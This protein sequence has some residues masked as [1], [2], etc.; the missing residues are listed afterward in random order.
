[1]NLDNPVQPKKQ[2]EEKIGTSF[3]VVG[4]NIIG[5]NIDADYESHWRDRDQRNDIIDRMKKGDASIAAVLNAIT[6]SLMS[7]KW[8]IEPAGESP[9]QI[10]HADFLKRA[11]FSELADGYKF[12]SFL[13]AALTCLP[14]GYSLFE[15][16]YKSKDGLVFWDRFAPRLQSSISRWGIEGEPWVDGHPTGIT[17][18]SYGSDETS[19]DEKKFTRTI[20]W[21]KLLRFTFNGA[22]NN[23]EG[24]S[25]L[26]PAYKHWYYK[27][28]YYKLQG[29]ANERWAAG[30]PV[31]FFNKDPSASEKTNIEGLLKSIRSNSQAFATFGPNIKEFKI[32][33]SDN[34]AASAQLENAIDGHDQKIYDSL[35]LGFLRLS[36]GKS[37][38]SYALSSDQSSFFMRS[39]QWV[40]DFIAGVMSS[41]GQKLIDINYGTQVDYPR[42]RTSDLT[43]TNV[44]E[45][46]KALVAGRTG[47]ILGWGDADEARARE[48]LGLPKLEQLGVGASARIIPQSAN[49]ATPAD[50]IN[51]LS[52]QKRVFTL[53]DANQPSDREKKFM[54]NIGEYENFLMSTYGRVE[55][56]VKAIESDL[57]DG[58]KA[59]YEKADTKR[60]DGHIVIIKSPKNSGLKKEALDL[61]KAQAKKMTRLLVKSANNNDARVMRILFDTTKSMAVSAIVDDEKYFAELSIDEKKFE[62]FQSGYRSNVNALIMNDPR[63]VSEQVIQNFNANTN[64]ELALSQLDGQIFNRNTLQLSIIS[65][66]RGAYNAAQY[67]INQTRGFTLY[68]VLAPKVV[69]NKLDLYGLTAKLLFSIYTVAQLDKAV[70]ELTDSRTANVVNGLGLHHNAVTYFYPIQSDQLDQEEKVSRAQR[71]QLKD[72]LS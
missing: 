42:M 41:S 65:H 1:M 16:V 27:D 32:V 3:G 39:L 21:N 60:V 37:G 35:L 63:R 61:V 28:L 13:P 14:Y 15:E 11:F 71:A 10:K 5:G 29:V 12:E 30:I 17:Q 70:S 7:A 55:K 59:L 45:F 22:G 18:W 52:E 33:S 2:K 36:A 40:A 62:A 44:G 8:Y 54:K 53:A 25:I 38:G 9:E 64:K 20:P 49:Q 23:Y 46:I 48:V 34:S 19:G 57:R 4:T 69:L 58:L 43:Q 6:S 67:D 47:G 26:R 56:E 51:G 24:E 68:K 66:P 31:V 72:N 50:A